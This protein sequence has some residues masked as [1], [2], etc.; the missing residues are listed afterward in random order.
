METHHDLP[1]LA[2]GDGAPHG[3]NHASQEPEEATNAVLSLVVCWDANVNVPH[4][5]VSVAESNGRDVTQ[6]R[7]LDGLHFNVSSRYVA[8]K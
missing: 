1:F 8:C 6:S 2:N 7:L 5:R 3:E 4:W